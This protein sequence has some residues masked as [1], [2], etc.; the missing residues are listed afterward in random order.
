MSK[1]KNLTLTTLGFAAAAAAALFVLPDHRATAQAP[2][3]DPRPGLGRV[4]RQSAGAEIFH[5]HPDHAR[6]CEEPEEGL[7]TPHRRRAAVG[8]HETT[9]GATPLFVNNT[10]YVGTP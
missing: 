9:W 2:D 10:V 5:R 7:G 6:Q 8:A 3:N 1:I 4:R